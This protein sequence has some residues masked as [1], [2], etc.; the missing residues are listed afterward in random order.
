VPN[1]RI[2]ESSLF[3]RVGDAS[4][5]S[6]TAVGALLPFVT[7]GGMGPTAYPLPS[8]ANVQATATAATI[9]ALANDFPGA[10]A[11]P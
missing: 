10:L 7:G 6:N 4:D 2:L 3:A 11:K 5:T 9:A 1:N 8:D